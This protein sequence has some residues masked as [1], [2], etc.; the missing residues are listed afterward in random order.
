LNLPEEQGEPLAWAL[1][2]SEIGQLRKA[3]IED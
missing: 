2:E 3:D 1:K